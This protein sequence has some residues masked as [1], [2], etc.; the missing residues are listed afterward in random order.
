[1]RPWLFCASLLALP[2]VA[3]CDGG[4]GMV[5]PQPLTSEQVGGVYTVCALVFTP[6]SGSPPAVDIRAAAMELSAAPV[7]TL[8]IARTVRSFELEYT[9]RGDVIKHRVQ[10][11]YELGISDIVL[12]AT[13]GASA[14]ALLLPN[15]LDLEFRAADKSLVVGSRHASHVVARADYERLAGQSYPNVTDQITGTLSG[16]FTSGSCD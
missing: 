16:R 7:P 11:S 5:D 9:R 12:T 10:G 14:T 13:T 6:A 8:T 4:R 2:I 15:R 3:A 1:M